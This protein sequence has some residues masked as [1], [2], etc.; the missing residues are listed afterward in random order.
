MV[1]ALF[2][3]VGNASRSQLAQALAQRHGAGLLDI[4]SAGTQPREA[5]DNRVASALTQRGFDVDALIPKTI[6]DVPGGPYEWMIRMGCGDV[7]LVPALH[8]EDWD[9]PAPSKLSDLDFEALCTDLEDRVIDFVERVRLWTEETG[10]AVDVGDHATLDTADIV[11]AVS[12][13]STA[14]TN[15]VVQRGGAPSAVLPSPA[16]PGASLLRPESSRD[17]T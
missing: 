2:V 6:D 8:R 5:L 16:A 7:L 3:C 17:A 4:H 9:Y 1:K 10:F 12:D 14:L 15:D 13:A 11:L